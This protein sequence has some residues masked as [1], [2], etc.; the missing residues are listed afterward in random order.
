LGGCFVGCKRRWV[1]EII[2]SNK[3]LFGLEGENLMFINRSKLF[4]RGFLVLA[5]LLCLAGIVVWYQKSTD[6]FYP[7]KS[8]INSFTLT[9][10]PT[11]QGLVIEQSRKFADAAGF[12]FDIV[13]YTPQG[14]NFLIDM[15]R[16]DLEVIIANAMLRADEFDVNFYNNDCIHPVIASDTVDVASNLESFI[17]DIPGAKF[18]EAR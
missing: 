6:C 13:Y 17:R 1:Y 10:D 8:P 14:D 4:V 5:L 7:G 12:K 18:A 2:Q 3:L 15:R 9:I 11:Q 16:K